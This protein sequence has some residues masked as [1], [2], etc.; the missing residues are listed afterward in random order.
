MA[1]DIARLLTDNGIFPPHY[2]PNRY[3]L[4]CPHCSATRQLPHQKLKCLSLMIEADKAYWKCHNC[5]WIGPE[6]S[7]KNSFDDRIRYEYP[8][9][10]FKIRN[11]KGRTPPYVWEH[12]NDHGQ[13]VSGA[14]NLGAALYRL[15]E[16]IARGGLI[17]VVEGEKDADN[18]W[19]HGFPAITS[20][21]GA[22]KP[23]QRPKWT[24][25]H[26]R[27][28]AG[29][30]I[31][32]LND[33]DPAGYEH[34]K[35]VV[36]C[37]HGIAKSI[38]R[39]DLKDHWPDIPPTG[40][41]SDFL[42]SLHST[43]YPGDEWVRDLLE[44]APL[45][46]GKGSLGPLPAPPQ[47]SIWISGD[48]LTSTQAPKQEWSVRDLIPA[49]QVCLLSGHGAVGKSSTALHLVAAHVLRRAWLN[50]DP[51]PGPAFFIDAED[52]LDVIHRRLDAIL[53]H[54]EDGAA[55]L[56][57][58]HILSLAGKGAVMATADRN[59]VVQPT[60]L[61][62]DIYQRAGDLK[63]QQIVIASSANVFAGSEVDRSQVTQFIDLLTR[64]AILTGGSVILISHPSLTGLNTNSGISGSTSWHNA[65][66]ARFYMKFVS[67]GGDQQDDSDLRVLE[68]QKNQ[69]GPP[70]Q[71]LTL[72][73]KHGLFLVETDGLS[74]LD[75]L[76]REAKGETK[77][78]DLLRRMLEGNRPVSAKPTARNYAPTAFSREPDTE[79][80]E[81]RD[82]EYAMRR[83]FAAKV[84]AVKQ[85]GKPSLGWERIEFV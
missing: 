47:P 11:P 62:H 57:E 5:N 80:L 10:N 48:V 45:I 76:A 75:K 39:L 65:V 32:V 66:R 8:G 70:A 33:N 52:D 23:G 40:D 7:G 19:R 36:D 55:D 25:E 63:P 59:G 83:L 27:Q 81:R 61:Y 4:T 9:G 56:A 3:Y 69:Y 42:E 44:D 77:F 20:P 82:F 43:D 17:A 29:L 73:F 18:L 64:I 68:F 6:A 50:F 21:H 28:L 84:I 67:N 71:S 37:S 79:G 46:N 2:E 34:A 30:E 60:A 51:T 54:Y 58:L 53:A 15:E 13:I 12:E 1:P 22:A 31:V 16:A 49:K 26:S 74:N 78:R 85:Y 38:R 35:A 24:T 72:R 41:I 14:N